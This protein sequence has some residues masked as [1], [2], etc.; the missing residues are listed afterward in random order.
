[1]SRLA[2]LAACDLFRL[3]ARQ[4]ETPIGQLGRRL[5]YRLPRPGSYSASFARRK[6][7]PT[8]IGK[9]N[10]LEYA[11]NFGVKVE[12]NGLFLANCFVELFPESFSLAYKKSTGL[13]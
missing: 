4:I 11:V 6:D 8:S 2:G 3:H 5:F 10:A 13:D 12:T 1:M 7:R 9:A